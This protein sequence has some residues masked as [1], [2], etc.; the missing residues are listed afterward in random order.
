MN[1]GPAAF[2]LILAGF[3][4]PDQLKGSIL[5]AVERLKF[6]SEQ[7]LFS[8]R[9]SIDAESSVDDMEGAVRMLGLAADAVRFQADGVMNA[10]ANVNRNVAM[11]L[12]AA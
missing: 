4:D 6:E 2:P 8:K 9:N 11:S 7:T 3:L 12:L 10:Q 1:A 5:T